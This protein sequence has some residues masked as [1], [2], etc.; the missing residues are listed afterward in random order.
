MTPSV[1]L[2]LS[3]TLTSETGIAL[4]ITVPPLLREH[5]HMLF[6][7]STETTFLKHTGSELEVEATRTLRRNE[8]SMDIH[9]TIH[10]FR[11]HMRASF[12]PSSMQQHSCQ[13]HSTQTL[14]ESGE[15]S[16]FH[17]RFLW[18]FCSA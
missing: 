6:D 2:R 7:K 13:L 4:L 10:P 14:E 8:I 3:L 12:F 9:N 5:A 18:P 15:S 17:S 1:R 16:F 11:I